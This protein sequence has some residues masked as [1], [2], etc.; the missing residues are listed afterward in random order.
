M[1]LQIG[2]QA[3]VARALGLN[4]RTVMRYENGKAPTW[5]AYAL[6]GLREELLRGELKSGGLLGEA[7]GQKHTV[8]MP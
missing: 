4:V 6:Y 5:W 2:S 1:R 3:A 7:V 8:P